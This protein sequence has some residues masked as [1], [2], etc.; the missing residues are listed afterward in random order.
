[1]QANVM[2]GWQ[3]ELR[4]CWRHYWRVQFDNPKLEPGYRYTTVS[5]LGITVFFTAWPGEKG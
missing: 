5:W 2:S 1:M 4:H 3:W